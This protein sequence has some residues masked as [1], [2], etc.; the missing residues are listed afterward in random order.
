[1]RR[2]LVSTLEMEAQTRMYG[3]GEA[4]ATN[5]RARG[6]PRQDEVEAIDSELLDGALREFL[7]TGYG[8]TSIS[9]IVKALGISKT[10]LYSR[11][12]SKDALFRAIVSRQIER[13]SAST[14]LQANGNWLEIGV[15]LRAYAN[16][17]LE[18]SLTGELRE[19]NRL[20]YSESPRFPELG[21][22]AAERTEIGVAQ[23]A[24]FIRQC[25]RRDGVPA[26]NPEGV[27]EAF[28]FMLRGW[29]VNVILSNAAVSPAAREAWVETAVHSLLSGRAEW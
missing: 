25:G 5:R 13:L 24:Q 1:M 22:A 14:A 6:R 19:V 18:I 20:I 16:R 3:P 12:P 26:R 15:G 27:A 2:S 21:A 9:Q 23:I 29:Y 11:Y 4:L 10:T 28:I 7:K 8:G 17:T